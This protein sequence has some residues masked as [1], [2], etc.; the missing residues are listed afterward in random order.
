ML[1][2]DGS[3]GLSS[4]E[5]CAAIKKLV[6]DT[7][8]PKPTHTHAR[9]HH[10]RLTPLFLKA[11]RAAHVHA[12]ERERKIEIVCMYTCVCVEREREGERVSQR[13]EGGREGKDRNNGE[14][15]R[16]RAEARVTVRRR[17]REGGV[18]GWIGRRGEGE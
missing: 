17:G 5:F 16:A 4:E 2:S 18:G 6:G 13:V 8:G 7:P 15:A 12:C 11:G 3:G 14:R 1:D 10:L 9:I